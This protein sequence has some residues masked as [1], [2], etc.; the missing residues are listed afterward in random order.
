MGR[1]RRT[2][3]VFTLSFLDCICCGFGAVILFYVIIS[4]RSGITSAEQMQDLSS[5]V[6]RLQEQVI[7]GRANLDTLRNAVE[8][9]QSESA[10][11]A[12][13]LIRLGAELEV[14]RREMSA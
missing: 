1:R 2:F 5:D 4:A 3:E 8:K 10:S 13:D 14:S 11:A 9:T 6:S 7:A 12:S